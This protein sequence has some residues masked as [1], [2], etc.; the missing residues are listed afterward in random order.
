MGEPRGNKAGAELRDCEP[1]GDEKK[2]GPGLRMGNVELILHERHER[3]KNET[4]HE[5]Q[6]EEG[7]NEEDRAGS[8]AKGFW[9]GTCFF[10]E[11]WLQS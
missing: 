1:G 10:H 9:N 3:R 4:S 5:I 8:G 6:K 11:G 7:G 2:Q